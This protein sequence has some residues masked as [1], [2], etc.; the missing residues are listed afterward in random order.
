MLPSAIR[1]STAC[2]PISSLPSTLVF[3]VNQECHGLALVT[4]TDSL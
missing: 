2:E 3:A 4:L 1:Y